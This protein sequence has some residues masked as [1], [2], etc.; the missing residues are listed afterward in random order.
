MT[1]ENPEIPAEPT[2]Q[3]VEEAQASLDPQTEELFAE[4]RETVVEDVPADS[5]WRT[6]E[7]T[8]PSPPTEPAQPLP[9]AEPAQ[10]EAPAGIPPQ[11]PVAGPK[12]ERTVLTGQLVWSAA[13]LL[14]A[15]LVLIS[16]VITAHL[17][18]FVWATL[19]AFFGLILIGAALSA[20]RKVGSGAT[21]PTS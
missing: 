7:F 13:L 6:A 20:G 3:E 1:K 2:V 15:L 10:S 8:L 16:L 14:A 9:D 5:D 11:E 18:P 19:M 12:P 17:T 21:K 4:V